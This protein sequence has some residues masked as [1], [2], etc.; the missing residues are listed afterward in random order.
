MNALLLAVLLALPDAGLGPMQFLSVQPG[1]ASVNVGEGVPL[2][3]EA[4]FRSR[5]GD[6]VSGAPT[7]PCT[8]K[9]ASAVATVDESGVVI[10]VRP[11]T[12]VITVS[13]G[14]TTAQSLVDVWD[15][16]VVGSYTGHQ[17][18]AKPTALT[19]TWC[20]LRLSITRAGVLLTE[21]SREAGSLP[22]ATALMERTFS[23][24]DGGSAVPPTRARVPPGDSLA[25]TLARSWSLEK[26][27]SWTGSTLARLTSSS[28]KPR[29]VF[30]RWT[31]QQVFK[32]PVRWAEGRAG[33][34]CAG[35]VFGPA[36]RSRAVDVLECEA[37]GDAC[38]HTWHL[39]PDGSD[40]FVEV[41]E[42]VD[43][44]NRQGLWESSSEELRTTRARSASG[45]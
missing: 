16:T 14:D 4:S 19:T 8:W 24:P 38:A 17:L 23:R 3:V 20:E 15:P 40:E 9:S 29:P 30:C 33:R 22:G 35:D 37:P 45:R 36:G 11:G 39:A 12:S 18:I 5:R 32:R 31:K 44:T 26:T 43:C 10:G 25:E 42:R 21:T 27:T 2:R 6:P 41:Q 28:D 7:E 1:R 13:C 34:E